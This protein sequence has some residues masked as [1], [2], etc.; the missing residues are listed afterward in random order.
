[1]ATR[2]PLTQCVESCRF[3]D[4]VTLWAREGLEHEDIV[5][6]TLARGIV[7]DG[8]RAQS[9]DVRWVKG[10][11]RA[12]EFKG[13]PYVGYRADPKA[14]MCVLR[15][16]ALDHLLGIV[17]RAEAPAREKLAEEFILRRDF[18]AWLIGMDL[19]LPAFWFGRVISR[20]AR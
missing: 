19:Q 20:E 6:S 10:N 13:F 16:T 9:V 18:R 7:C 4:V 14:P 2:R 11:D 1:M 8:L 17:N 3:W 12:V 15:A 5:A